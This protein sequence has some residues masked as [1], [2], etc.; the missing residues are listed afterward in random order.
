[1]PAYF[2]ELGAEP[3]LSEAEMRSRRVLPR[4][5]DKP[6]PFAADAHIGEPPQNTF[7]RDLI[8]ISYFSR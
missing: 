7:S 4:N 3:F 2:L 8:T 5:A 1:L 6:Q